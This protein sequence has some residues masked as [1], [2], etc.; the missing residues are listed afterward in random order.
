MSTLSITT[1]GD[2]RAGSGSAEAPAGTWVRRRADVF[3]LAALAVGV[4]ASRLPYLVADTMMSKD[5]PLYI[6]SLDLGPSYAVPMPGNI[7]FVL[8]GKLATWLWPDPVAAFAAVNILL[9]FLGAAGVLLLLSRAR[10]ADQPIRIPLPRWFARSGS[11]AAASPAE[12]SAAPAG[13]RIAGAWSPSGLARIAWSA[14]P[15]ISSRRHSIPAIR[16]RCTRAPT[17]SGSS[18]TTRSNGS[19]ASAAERPRSGLQWKSRSPRW[20][21]DSTSSGQV[22]VTA[23]KSVSASFTAPR[24][25]ARWAAKTS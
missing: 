19:R 12:S 18:R 11:E 6:V 4:I 15:I 1:L 16:V 23:L 17:C 8:L 7:G 9:T 20:N 14:R 3:C 2:D 24:S 10:S 13:A 22:A 25:Q 21:Q 5:G